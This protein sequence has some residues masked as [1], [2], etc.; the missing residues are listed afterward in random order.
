MIKRLQKFHRPIEQENEISE[1]L[2]GY[3]KHDLEVVKQRQ[4]EEKAR[5]KKII[6]ENKEAIENNC[7]LCSLMVGHND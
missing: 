2:V 4:K 3:Q 6:K 1:L 5:T 7:S